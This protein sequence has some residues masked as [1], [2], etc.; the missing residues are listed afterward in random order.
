MNE[1]EKRQR[2]QKRSRAGAFRGGCVDGAGDKPITPYLKAEAFE[3]ET[4]KAMGVAFEKVCLNLGLSLRTDPATEHVARII[5]ELART[6][7][8]DPEQ[9]YHRALSHFGKTTDHRP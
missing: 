3:P 8:R 2:S 6:G 5:I 7:H 9:L 4:A 1:S